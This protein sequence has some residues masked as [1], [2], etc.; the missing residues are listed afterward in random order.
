MKYAIN[1]ST[2]EVVEFDVDDFNRISV[3]FRSGNWREAT[4]EEI[5]TYHLEQAKKAK[6]AEICA[7]R[8]KKIR[9][10]SVRYSEAQA[11][12]S[13]VMAMTDL[14]SI[15]NYDCNSAFN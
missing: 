12:E 6:C 5:D 1:T 8:D 7:L 14:D 4:Q 15:N 9:E 3:N 13:S 10:D 11:G 2:N